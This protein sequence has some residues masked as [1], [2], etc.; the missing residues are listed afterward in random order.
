MTKTQETMDN[1]RQTYHSTTEIDR[2]TE[3]YYAGLT[4]REEERE[5]RRLLA[6]ERTDDDR[7]ADRAVAAYTAMMRPRRR[8]TRRGEALRRPMRIAAAVI[9]GAGLTYAAI[10]YSPGA[11][12]ECYAM[13]DQRRIDDREAVM[14]IMEATLGEVAR[15]QADMRSSV[16]DQFNEIS[17]QL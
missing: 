17:S 8:G 1:N 14:D 5:L 13:V 9:V 6:E 4:S 12:D 2:L 16:A 3:R 10:A 7:D 11:G 15:A